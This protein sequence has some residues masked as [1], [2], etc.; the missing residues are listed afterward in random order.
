MGRNVPHTQK[1]LDAQL[2]EAGV[3]LPYRE[4]VSPLCQSMEVQGKRLAN[5]I[6][7]QAME[8]CD[9]KP[10]GSPGELTIRRYARFAAGGPGLVWY[11]ATA[12]CPEGRANP[13]QSWLTEKNMGEF[14]RMVSRIKETCLRENGFIPMVICQ[15]THSGRYS[16]PQGD[17]APLIAYN[18]PV[19]EGEHPLPKTCILSDDYLAALP[20]QFAHSAS[21]ALMA[22]F[23]GVDVKCCHR[24]L[25]CELLSAYTREGRYGGDFENRTRLL[26]EAVEAVQA[27]VG[28]FMLV[29]S[30]MNIYDGFPYPYGFGVQEG[31]GITPD[32]T[33]PVKLAKQ[34][35]GQG[36]NLLDI[37][38][39]NP[40]FNPHVNRPFAKG[41][42]EPP[43]HPMAGV[44]RMLE[45]TRQIKTA[46][47][48][49][50]IIC[51]GITYLG[52]TAPNVTAA[53]VEEGWF[54][55]AGFGRQTLAYPDLA[56]DIRLRGALDPARLCVAC[57]KCTEIMRQKGGTPG[58]VVRDGEVYMPIYKQ[59]VLK[60]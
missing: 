46:V 48:D 52:A 49:C 14:G 47:P 21:L 36:I 13:H 6:C 4:S 22:G 15:L 28:G 37:T 56:R 57:G 29:T 45:G 2:H 17:P 55:M 39:G 11:E 27:R 53:C 10:D 9:S 51:S 60:K 42:Y 16:K 34:L 33:E 25:L 38:M 43:E 8:G 5:R 32:Y 7:Y 50:K 26:R 1:E 31:A 41:P 35:C 30:R 18:N 23:D 40:Y 12:I 3:C 19:F 54:D 20:E 44:A 24:Y 59:F 58:C